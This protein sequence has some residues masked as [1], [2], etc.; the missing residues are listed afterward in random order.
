LWNALKP[1]LPG[2]AKIIVMESHD[3]GCIYRG[4]EQA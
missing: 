1:A 4:E 3:S 2:L